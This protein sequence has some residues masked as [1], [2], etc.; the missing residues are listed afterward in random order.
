MQ[1]AKP[2]RGAS[3][4]MPAGAGR[5]PASRAPPAT[6]SAATVAH[7]HVVA[8]YPPDGN[9][10]AGTATAASTAGSVGTAS[11]PHAPRRALRTGDASSRSTDGVHSEPEVAA[12][13]VVGVCDPGGLVVAGVG[14]VHGLLSR[15]AAV[16][17]NTAA[18]DVKTRAAV[19]LP[20]VLRVRVKWAEVGRDVR[21]L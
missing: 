11:R 4:A 16:A 15:I 14:A 20:A 17:Q 6:T 1:I 18:H 21:D 12:R 10:S 7:A 13:V 5:R 9:A 8:A 19:R 3:I 2:A